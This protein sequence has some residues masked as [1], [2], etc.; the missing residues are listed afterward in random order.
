MRK[1]NQMKTPN[2]DN[3]FDVLRDKISDLL[4][5]TEMKMEELI[6][7]YNTKYEEDYDAPSIETCD[8]SSLFSQLQDFCED[9]I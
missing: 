3:D 7:D 1:K 8:L 2:A 4:D 5:D 9:H 6:S